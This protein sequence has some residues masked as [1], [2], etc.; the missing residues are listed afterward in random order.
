MS[1][2]PGS[3]YFVDGERR[4][5]ALI[6]AYWFTPRGI[7]ELNEKLRA[8]PVSLRIRE[9]A[10]ELTSEQ[11]SRLTLETVRLAREVMEGLFRRTRPS[12]ERHMMNYPLPEIDPELF[13]SPTGRAA[14]ERYLKIL[15]AHDRRF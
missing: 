6:H 9:I 4:V 10:R 13:A 5:A 8:P 15:R 12:I 3:G 1:P 14:S 7:Q 11:R 2:A